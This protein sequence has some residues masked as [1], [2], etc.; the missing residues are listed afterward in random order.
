MNN[1]N[2]N[3]FFQKL[4]TNSCYFLSVI[5]HLRLSGS[6]FSFL[7]SV[8]YLLLADPYILSVICCVLVC[9][10]FCFSAA[11]CLKTAIYCILHATFYRLSASCYPHCAVR[12]SPTFRTF[13]YRLRSYCLSTIWAIRLSLLVEL[14]DASNILLQLC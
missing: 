4:F 9:T 6:T 7:H 13:C 8:S 10:F 14:P 5:F 2:K 11:Y 3:T 12:H 1:S